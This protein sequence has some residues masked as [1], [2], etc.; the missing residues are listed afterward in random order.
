MKAA[1]QT[2]VDAHLMISNPDQMV[3]EYLSAGADIVTFH[4]EATAHANRLANLIREKRRPRLAL[5]STLARPSLPSTPLSR[6][7]TWC[8]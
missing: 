7:W 1:T 4:Y 3:P 5:P 8:S 6:T 2:P